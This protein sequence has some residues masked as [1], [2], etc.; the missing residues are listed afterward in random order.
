MDQTPSQSNDEVLQII[1][2]ELRGTLGPLAVW[3][4][5]LQSGQA[6]AEETKQAGEVIQRGVQV[7]NRL[8]TDLAALQGTEDA[9]LPLTLTT[10]DLREVVLS[11]I[12][13][14]AREA[15]GRGVELVARVESEAV[16]VVGDPVRLSQIISNLLDNALKFT[17]TPG[18]IVVDL[19]TK[20]GRA[21]L[22]VTDTGAGISPEF[23]PYAFDKFA[24]ETPNDADRRGRGLGLYLVKRL[25]ELHGGTVEV[26]S[27]GPGQGSRFLV[28][29]P[30]AMGTA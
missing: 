23:L 8:A 20:E 9:E 25:V 17:D 16:T 24:R 13:M 21:R 27:R 19:E 18:K 5:L 14:I 26:E 6:K 30:L 7:L 1:A 22:S 12:R 2:H 10:F 29:L 3:S 4:R 11:A 15:T 28:S